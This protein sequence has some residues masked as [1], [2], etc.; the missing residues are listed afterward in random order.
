M[1][2]RVFLDA[3]VLF[4][5]VYS[6]RGFA[7]DLLNAAIDGE[8]ELSASSDVVDEVARNLGNK[9]PGALS[10]LRG[11]LALDVISLVVPS[12]DGIGDAAQTVAVKDSHVVAG[13]LSADAR[14]I[15]TYD[16]RHLLSQA[17]VIREAFGVEVLTPEE[18]LRRLAI[19]DTGA[20]S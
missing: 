4:A 12:S 8:V 11:Y 13:A 7:R 15:A 10:R 2:G 18:V 17:D 5:A 16:R 19:D 9:A 20:A 14:V 6:A 3:S 1:S